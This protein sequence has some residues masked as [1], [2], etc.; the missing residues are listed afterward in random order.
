MPEF[1]AYAKAAP[2]SVT[3]ASGGNGPPSHIAGALFNMM[4]G[5][6]MTHVPYYGAAPALTDLL[7]G[8]VQVYF[9]PTLSSIEHI[10]AGRL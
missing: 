10:K 1:I 8:E 5:I 3:M 6:N 2:G 9:G 7:G 4:A